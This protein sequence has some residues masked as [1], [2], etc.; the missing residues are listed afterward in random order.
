ML[1]AVVRRRK[2]E[3]IFKKEAAY[4]EALRRAGEVKQR[5]K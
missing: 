3:V 4:V 5:Q 1:G 2:A